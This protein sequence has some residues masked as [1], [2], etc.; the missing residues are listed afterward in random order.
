[1]PPG[2]S[3]SPIAGRRRQFTRSPATLTFNRAK[4]QKGD[5]ADTFSG[6][7]YFR[8]KPGWGNNETFKQKVGDKL[9]VG[10]ARWN[11]DLKVYTAR[12][13]TVEEAITWCARR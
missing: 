1:M 2:S 4:Y 12:V 8:G 10:P 13:H 7:I 5:K 11:D 6:W 3:A 9:L